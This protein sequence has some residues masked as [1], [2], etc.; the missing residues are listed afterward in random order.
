MNF[1]KTLTQPPA[2]IEAQGALERADELRAVLTSSSPDEI[3]QVFR[4]NGDE[5]WRDIAARLTVAGEVVALLAE[6]V[7][8]LEEGE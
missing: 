5:T 6:R 1:L 4:L 3:R 7:E 2:S 8:R